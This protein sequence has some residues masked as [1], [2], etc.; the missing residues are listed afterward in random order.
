M[1]DKMILG[2]APGVVKLGLICLT[3][4]GSVASGATAYRPVMCRCP[5]CGRPVD[6]KAEVYLTAW[7]ARVL[8][9]YNMFYKNN[10]SDLYTSQ[11]ILKCRS[12]DFII[13]GETYEEVC[14]EFSK[15]SD[16]GH[17]GFIGY[18]DDGLT[19]T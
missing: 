9:H 1:A 18:S 8:N 6:I 17:V 7:G 4:D 15:L 16:G 14:S 12:C 3:V 10:I 19:L 11:L 5:R 13:F 2:Q